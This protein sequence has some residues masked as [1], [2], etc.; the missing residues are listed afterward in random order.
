MNPHAPRARLLWDGRW[1]WLLRR[2]Q[3]GACQGEPRQQD[4]AGGRHRG[5]TEAGW[6]PAPPRCGHTWGW[7]GLCPAAPSSPVWT[8]VLKLG[9]AESER[10]RAPQH[11]TAGLLMQ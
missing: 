11:S 8:R 9:A 1:L 4:G 6:R 5:C 3:D 7:A 2:D 10:L